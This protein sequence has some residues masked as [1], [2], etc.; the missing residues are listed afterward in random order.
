MWPPSSYR[1]IYDERLVEAAHPLT[2]QARAVRLIEEVH[3][4]DE[5]ADQE[6]YAELK[7]R[8]K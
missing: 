2:D 1:N 4:E 6:F 7:L 3:R 8:E 5:E